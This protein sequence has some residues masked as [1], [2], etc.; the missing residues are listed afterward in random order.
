MSESTTRRRASV[1]KLEPA[2]EATPSTDYVLPVVGVHVPSVVVDIAFWGGLAR[3]APG[4][5]RP[6][7]VG[8]ILP[9]LTPF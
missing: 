4:R 3:R 1:T 8:S 9:R 7:P 2:E 6:H 5:P